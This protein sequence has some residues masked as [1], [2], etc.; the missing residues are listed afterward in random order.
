VNSA[1]V[2]ERAVRE[3]NWKLLIDGAVRY[4]LF[5]F[6]KDPGERNDLTASNPAIVRQ[7]R[8][9]IAAWEKDVD[10]EAKARTSANRE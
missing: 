5:D 2:Y 10:S 3:G 7:L 1:G 4:H 9:K 8:Q 6:V